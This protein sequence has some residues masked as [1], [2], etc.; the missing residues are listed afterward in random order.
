MDDE[1]IEV[2]E[3]DKAK[4]KISEE[5]SS[6]A[7]KLFKN[8]EVEK[9]KSIMA[10]ARKDGKLVDYDYINFIR[11]LNYKK[12]L[13]TDFFAISQKYKNIGLDPKI[14]FG[15]EIESEGDM[16]EE[17]FLFGDV[18]L[19]ENVWKSEA[20]GSLRDDGIE[21]ISPVFT[22]NNKDVSEIYAMCQLLQDS[23]NKAN[24]RCGAHVHI[25]ADYLKSKEAYFNL[26]EI[27]G[28]TEK[29]MY[30]ISNEANTLPRDGIVTQAH[31]I[32]PKIAEYLEK[33]Q[34]RFEKN[35]YDGFIKEI[36]ENVQ[37]K[38]EDSPNIGKKTFDLNFLN[39]NGEKN[40]LEFRM[41]NGTLSPDT[42]VENIRLYG[43]IVE[44]SQR[45]GEIENKPENEITLEERE[46]YNLKERLKSDISDDEK[47]EILFQLL[48]SEKDRDVYR[49]K[50]YANSKLLEEKKCELKKMQF[51]KIDIKRNKNLNKKINEMREIAENANIGDIT[52]V[53][54]VIISSIK[55]NEISKEGKKT[56]FQQGDV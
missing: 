23:K 33:H 21:M 7:L 48:F 39:V 25:G 27:F 12:F 35:N 46:L 38:T 53:E 32:I 52:E 20:D 15:T 56:E 44:T 11:R 6:E 10:Q 17:L 47:S 31:P 22:D 14:T 45:L 28:N 3:E 13:N 50:Y 40:T 49:N 26:L 54:Q 41:A 8:N 19:G 36:Q 51:R 5:I 16:A 37:V 4:R 30:L 43:K 24:A 42:W 55:E 18:K 9:A 2:S 1:I 34:E 29:I